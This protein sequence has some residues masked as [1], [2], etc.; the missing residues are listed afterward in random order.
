MSFVNKQAL[1][2]AKEAH[3]LRTQLFRKKFSYSV[4][5]QAEEYNVAGKIIKKLSSDLKSFEVV[6]SVASD[7]WDFDNN[8]REV[9][10]FYL[11]PWNVLKCYLESLLQ[12]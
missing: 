3:Q 10:S 5:H 12:V 2:Y 1:S 7:I 11:S 9:D 4:A 8:S 6:Q